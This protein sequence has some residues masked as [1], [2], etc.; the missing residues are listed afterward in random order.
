MTDPLF[1]RISVVGLGYIGLPTAALFA[2]RGVEVI[3]VDTNP[4][5]VDMVNCGKVH[6]AEPNLESIVREAVDAGF[7]SATSTPEPADA[8]LIAVPTPFRGENYEPDLTYVESAARAIAPVLSAGNLVVLESTSPV[9]V[10][11][12]M[13]GWFADAR[14]DL[15]FPQIAGAKSDVRIAYCPER[16]APGQT[17]WELEYN[18]RVVGGMT[19]VCST[20]AIELYKT[21]VKAECISASHPRVAEMA[22]LA[23]NSFRDVNIAFANELSMMADLFGVDVNELIRL[24]NLHPR[25]NILN[26]GPGV[27]GHCIAVDP[28]FLIHSCP[29]SSQLLRVARMVNEQKAEWVTEKIVATADRLRR[30]QGACSVAIF[31]ATFKE[32]VDDFRNSPA[33]EIATYLL[34]QT[35]LEVF[36]VEPYASEEVKAVFGSRLIDAERALQQADLPVVLVAHEDFAPLEFGEQVLKFV[37]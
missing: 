24:C 18:S 25:V 33:L 10:T 15:S 26:P 22:K 17:L 1:K 30:A 28:W 27:G 4:A 21:I 7:L 23:E 19:A 14:P 37:S 12:R 36:L 32:N 13:A 16:V 9:G 35:T 34:E 5:I 3:G 11:D 20:L 2:S 29:S 31:G 6:I 8:Y